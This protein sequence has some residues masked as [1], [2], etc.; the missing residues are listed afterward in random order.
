MNSDGHKPAETRF[1]TSGGSISSSRTVKAL[2]II[3]SLI[4]LLGTVAAFSTA[5]MLPLGQQE[6]QLRIKL[7]RNG[8]QHA[9]TASLCLLALV[10]VIK[11]S[12]FAELAT[13]LASLVTGYLALKALASSL[14]TGFH[15]YHLIEPL[16]ILPSVTFIAWKLWGDYIKRGRS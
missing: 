4:Y 16:I 1:L 5:A 11:Q 8:F 10:F 15:A 2:L 12:R 7:E 6:D 14:V 3:L 13:G 9:F